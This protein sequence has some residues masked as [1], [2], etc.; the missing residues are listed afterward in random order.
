LSVLLCRSPDGGSIYVLD[1]FPHD[2]TEEKKMV[3]KRFSREHYRALL[4]MPTRYDQPQRIA[5]LY[6]G[7]VCW[8]ERGDQHTIAQLANE[9]L[10]PYDLSFQQARN[11]RAGGAQLVYTMLQTGEFPLIFGLEW[12][13]HELHPLRCITRKVIGWGALQ[14]ISSPGEGFQVSCR[15]RFERVDRSVPSLR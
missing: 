9:E 7:P 5:A 14:F 8:A 2:L 6:L 1:E 3:V 11:D 4:R 12:R 15:F 13:G 10:E